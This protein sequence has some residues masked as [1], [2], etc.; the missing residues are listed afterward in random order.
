MVS[1]FIKDAVAQHCLMY[2]VSLQQRVQNSTVVIEGEVLNQQ[3]F[4]DNAQNAIYTAN[5]VKIF[6]LFKGTIT[7]STIDVITEGGIVG[8]NKYVVRPSLS[9][10]VG[11]IGIFTILN[12]TLPIPATGK[13]QYVPYSG[14]QGFTKYDPLTQIPRSVF[15]TYTNEQQLYQAIMSFTGNNFQEMV[16]F[17]AKKYFESFISVAKAVVTITNVT[18]LSV[19]AGTYT[20]ITITGSGFGT[21]KG[22]VN[23]KNADDGGATWIAAP[24][25]HI[26][27]WTDI[28]ITVWVPN[29]ASNGAVLVQHATSGQAQSSQT[30]TVNYNI[31]NLSSGGKEYTGDHINQNGLGGYTY[32]YNATFYAN[33]DAVAR[34]EEALNAWRCQT[35]INWRTAGAAT[36]TTAC[37]SGSDGKNVVSFDNTC[38]LPAGVLGT[39]YSNY[40]GCSSGGFIYWSVSDMDIKFDA[41]ANWNFLI[42]APGG[43][44]YDFLSVATHEVGHHHQQGH[45]GDG[46]G[47]V[48]FWSLSNGAM[49]RT[50]QAAAEIAGGNYLMTRANAT[51]TTYTGSTGGSTT[52]NPCGSSKMINYPC[53]SPNCFDVIQNGAETGVDCGGTCI[54]CADRCSNGVQDGDETGLDCGGISC[55]ACCAPTANDAICSA[56]ILANGGCAIGESNLCATG[57]FTSGCATTANTLWYSFTLTGTNDGVTV[58][59]TDVTLPGAGAVQLAM[60]G[61]TCAASSAVGDTCGDAGVFTFQNLTP[62]GTYRFSVSTANGLE[63]TYNACISFFDDPCV[64]GVPAN[65]LI[66]SSTVLPPAGC[67]ATQKNT[68][69]TADYSGGCVSAGNPSVWYNI[70]LT[71]GNNRVAITFSPQTFLGNVELFLFSGA[72]GAPVGIT[73]LCQAPNSTFTFSQL[74]AGTPYLLMVSTALPNTGTFDIC[75]AQSIDPCFGNI[76]NNDTICNA[77]TLPVDGTCLASQ[78]IDCATADYYGGCVPQNNITL[79]YTFTLTGLNTDMEVNFTAET[80][81]NNVELYLFGT[82][83]ANPSGL[84]AICNNPTPPT[85]GR[86]HFS[87]LTATQYWVMVSVTSGE[88]GTFTICGT[89]STDACAGLVPAND[90]ICNATTLP[91][92]AA[93]GCPAGELAGQK[94]TCSTGDMFGGCVQAGY[95]SV[96]YK[97]TLTGANNRVDVTFNGY[98]FP[99]SIF[100]FLLD[101]GAC[102]TPGPV[103]FSQCALPSATFGFGSPGPNL[104][105]GITYWMLV[106][107]PAIEAGIFDICAVQSI[108][109]PGSQTG[110]Q[111]DCDGAKSVCSASYS[112]TTSFTGFG[113]TQEVAGTCLLSGETNSLWYVFTVQNAGDFCFNI[114]TANDYDFALYDI[115]TIG[116]AGIPTATPVRCNFSGTLG[117]TG[118]VMPTGVTTPLS[119]TATGS[120]TMPCLPVTDGQSFALIVDNWTAD[121]NG[122]TL[123]FPGSATIVDAT[124]PNL[125]NV[126]GN[127]VN[128]TITVTLDE[129]ALC[130]SVKT[131]DFLLYN[132]TTFQWFTSAVTNVSGT[133]CTGIVGELTTQIIITHDG[134][135]TSGV[136]KLQMAASP[137][138]QDKCGNK[139]AGG[140]VKWFDYLIPTSVTLTA[141]PSATCTPGDLVTL[142]AT[143]APPGVS[144]TLTPGGTTNSSGIFNVNPS[145]NT[146]YTVSVTWGGC[147]KTTNATVTMVDNVIS[148]IAPVNPQVCAVPTTL[149]VSTTINGTAC[150]GCTYIWSNGNTGATAIAAATGTYTVTTT[151]SQGCAGDNVPS[152]T[153]SLASAGAGASCAV[154]Y[155]H[156]GAVGAGDTKL[157]PTTL[158]DA[159]TKALCTNTV[160][161]MK[162]GIYTFTDRVI[163][164]SYVTIEGGYDATY[165]AKSSDLTGGA[166]TTV[167]RRTNAA[168]SDDANGCS[169]LRVQA[170]EDSW[171]I[172]DIRIEMPGSP[173]VTA[174]PVGVNRTNYGIRMGAGS[175]GYK[176]IRCYIDAGVGSSP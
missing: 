99:D 134:T 88:T 27:T 32:T 110:P 136:Y 142:T 91:L 112:N 133:G 149:T 60:Y 152:S 43:A 171:R 7:A 151:T 147:T 35:A 111:Q 165:T 40:S 140:S 108:T 72:C 122:Y 78:T 116:C 64:G 166:A 22:T 16:P 19:T 73:S 158:A 6:K 70:T 51:E 146:T 124:A 155:V 129:E 157:T 20:L 31:T 65:D 29:G 36:T 159:L 153:V 45:Y 17:N 103:L 50:L 79:W 28:S 170:G 18:P 49:S 48:M 3:C 82:A 164:N 77:L 5:T 106:A 175:T 176:I 135:L 80:F 39:A 172:Q 9:L 126:S 8:T 26:I 148:A 119:V 34:F 162:A 87:G 58:T 160:L 105:T 24:A 168:D 150:V 41:N 97:F 30:L 173:S 61:N 104:Q 12:S 92:N 161:K 1:L 15:D 52:T 138:L 120:P 76:P 127:C 121:N 102:G 167:L 156:N 56:I 114:A 98:N 174:H 59:I 95:I 130:A 4:W 10:Q 2:P 86:F 75:A 100:V 125:W 55:A 37:Q 139:I 131:A 44:Q 25:D 63:G 85:T 33:T 163:V 115:T 21:V 54:T 47:D 118:L 132:S 66:C 68:C 71:G 74:T 14:A 123:T 145:A 46:A 137:T 141:S 62:L 38:L 53:T 101:G 57:D 143:G 23:F 67:V 117:N 83:C 154:L 84:L 69:A 13:S 107:T 169:M 109:P 93:G 128:N 96:W 89:Q 11:D 81:P 144:Y 90:S 113:S 42:A 94:N